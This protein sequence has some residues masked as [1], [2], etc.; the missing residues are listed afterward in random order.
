MVLLAI[1]NILVK[2]GFSDTVSWWRHGFSL[3]VSWWS[4]HVNNYTKTL[5]SVSRSSDAVHSVVIGAGVW[6]KAPQRLLKLHLR[7]GQV[8]SL[9][10]PC[11]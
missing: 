7:A 10:L 5:L 2:G 3:E 11:A 9:D 1:H 8:H 4:R 6:G